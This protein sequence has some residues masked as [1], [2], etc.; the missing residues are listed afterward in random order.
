MIDNQ[1]KLFNNKF[2]LQYILQLLYTFRSFHLIQQLHTTS[3]QWYPMNAK[4]IYSLNA[5]HI[6]MN[7]T[8]PRYLCKLGLFSNFIHIHTCNDKSFTN[9]CKQSETKQKNYHLNIIFLGNIRRRLLLCTRVYHNQ[10][11]SDSVYIGILWQRPTHKN[12]WK[13]LVFISSECI[14]MISSNTS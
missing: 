10:K 13:R 1:N 9:Q 7:S 12:L 4:I 11:A 8:L 14:L 5:R 6:S 2:H 3:A